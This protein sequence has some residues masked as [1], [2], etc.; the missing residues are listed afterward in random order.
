MKIALISAASS[1]HILRWANALS[2]KGND[3]TVI[4]LKN[5]IADKSLYNEKVNIIYLPF[6]APFGYY[7]SVNAL[8]KIV[9]K[10]KFDVLNVHYAS[11]YGTLARLA[12]LKKA[13]LNVW[14]SDVYDFPY[15]SSFNM[16]LIKKNLG[17]F[18]HI[19][20]TSKC[21]AEQTK[22]LVERSDIEI[23]PFGVDTLKFYSKPE[24]KSE[25]PIIIGTVKTLDTKY[26]IEDTIKAFMMLCDKLKKENNNL[27]NNLKYEIYGKGPLKE[28]LQSI[29]DSSEYKDKIELCGYVQNDKLPE[30]LNSFS[31][32]CVNSIS[33]SF[34][35]AA[36][37]AM[38]C[39]IP[40]I[41]SDADGFKEVIEDKISGTIV[42]KG[43]VAAI[44]DAMY[45]LLTD[46]EK[47]KAYK[48]N[49][50][51]RVKKYFNWNDNVDK[52]IS[53]YKGMKND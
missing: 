31:L 51:E 30:I 1:V 17:Y 14:G 21:M 44:S 29:I 16:R 27:L 32:F 13:L 19:A 24:L 52:M 40:V 33:E 42:E 35:V 10:E 26:G 4:S 7:L 15:Q 23:T 20:S 8:K 18:D 48:N 2:E 38:A 43:N 39:G 11:G 22:K 34:G 50:S 46:K 41:A 25:N 36:V 5:H 45:A 3:I 49:G 47:A 9:K 12:R 28:K 37:E 6:S 53:T